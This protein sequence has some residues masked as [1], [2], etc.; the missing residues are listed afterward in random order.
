MR[1]LI[2]ALSFVPLMAL[3]S[4]AS[5]SISCSI[6]D[7]SV[8]LSFEAVFSHGLGEGLVNISGELKAAEVLT[9]A[10]E[11]GPITQEDVKQYWMYGPDLKLRIYRE[12]KGE[13]HET[14]E[15]VIETTQDNPKE[16]DDG[17]YSGKYTGSVFRMD[18]KA[19]PEGTSKTVKGDVT[20]SVGS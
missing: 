15:I 7:K 5:G 3:P 20:C 19:G 14:I 18:E 1:S 9:P 17:A 11:T 13:P 6:E 2:L 8:T 10:L 4:H 12:S 16:P